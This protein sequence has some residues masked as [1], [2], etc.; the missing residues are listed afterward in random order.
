MSVIDF[1]LGKERCPRC[2]GTGKTD[3]GYG[4]AINWCDLCDNTKKV[5]M[6]RWHKL[7]QIIY[8]F[9]LKLIIK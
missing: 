8:D 7:K 9:Y 6:Y 5:K 4:D 1:I 2:D 3:R